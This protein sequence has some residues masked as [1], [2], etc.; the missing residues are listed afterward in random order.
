[1]VQSDGSFTVTGTGDIAGYGIAS[2]RA[3]GDDDVVQRSLTG[4][5]IGL[6]AIVALGVL[7]GTSEYKTGTIRTTFTASP[8]RGRVLAAKA[9]VVG[10]TVFVAGLI[11]SLVAFLITQPALHA[12]GYEPPAYPYPSLADGPVLRAVVGT[13]LFL[14]VLALLSLAIG[15]IRRRTVGAIILVLVLIVVPQIVAPVL[16]LNAELWVYRLTPAA[17]LAIQRTRDRF[18]SAIPPWGG[19]AVLCGYLAVALAIAAWQLRKRDA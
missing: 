4:V 9:I 1:M 15:M 12:N 16:S 10:G 7:F 8:R 6:M 18:D 14:A 2:F 5:Q 19:F 13:A 11:A 3:P 17:G